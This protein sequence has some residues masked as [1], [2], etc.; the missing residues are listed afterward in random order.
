MD[1]GQ[2]REKKHPKIITS[3][4][5]YRLTLFILITYVGAQNILRSF[6]TVT[7]RSVRRISGP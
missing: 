3:N 4:N 2:N 7:A 6:Q 1:K 5:M